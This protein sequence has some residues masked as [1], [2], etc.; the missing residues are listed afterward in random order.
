[1][2]P[3]F[4]GTEKTFHPQDEERISTAYANSQR[5]RALER[6]IREGKRNLDLMTKTKDEP[7]INKAKELLRNREVN[8][9]EFIGATGRKRRPDR[10]E[11]YL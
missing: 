1:M 5:Q 3:Y 9:R 10:E 7:S 11:I 8:M 2:Y 6:S 4:P